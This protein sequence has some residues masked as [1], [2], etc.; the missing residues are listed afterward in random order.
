MSAGLI[1][2]NNSTPKTHIRRN[3]LGYLL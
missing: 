3:D 2:F 1:S